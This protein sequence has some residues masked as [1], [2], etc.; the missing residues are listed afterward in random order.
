VFPLAFL[1]D[2]LDYI[3]YTEFYGGGT[4]NHRGIQ[5]LFSSILPTGSRYA[6]PEYPQFHAG[7]CKVP[8]DY[9]ENADLP[10]NFLILQKNIAKPWRI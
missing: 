2:I 9:A 10:W 7:G 8:A 1:C 5:R 3:S 4:E 6:V